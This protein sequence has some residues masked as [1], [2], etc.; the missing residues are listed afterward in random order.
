MYG[1]KT[2]LR[3][4]DENIAKEIEARRL[5]SRRRLNSL[6]AYLELQGIEYVRSNYE[7]HATVVVKRADISNHERSAIIKKNLDCLADLN[8]SKDDLATPV[9]YYLFRIYESVTEMRVSENFYSKK[10]FSDSW[11]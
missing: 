11:E 3:I 8:Y 10:M 4:A 6:M 1:N 2:K 5:N 9:V 7:E